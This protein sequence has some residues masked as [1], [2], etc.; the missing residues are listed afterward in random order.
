MSIQIKTW[1]VNTGD[2]KFTITAPTKLLARLN[3]IQKY[4]YYSGEYKISRA[5]TKK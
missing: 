3:F 2:L 5:R 1:I 4:G